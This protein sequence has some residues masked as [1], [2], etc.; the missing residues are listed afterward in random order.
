MYYY[1]S[2]KKEKTIR[3]EKNKS[4]TAME[5][6]L[7]IWGFLECPGLYCD[8]SVHQWPVSI[9]SKFSWMIFRF[10]LTVNRCS[11][12]KIK[13]YLWPHS[14]HITF[15][16]FWSVHLSCCFLLFLFQLWLVPEWQNSYNISLYQEKGLFDIK[17]VICLELKQSKKVM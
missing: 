11:F 3:H 8:W 7:W 1:F 13:C 9:K 4:Q 17:L 10:L 2:I 5:I 16:V 14:Q 6:S 15:P 12:F